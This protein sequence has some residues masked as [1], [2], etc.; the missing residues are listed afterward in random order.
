M[1]VICVHVPSAVAPD[2]WAQESQAPQH[3]VLQHTPFT[4]KPDEHW[5]FA[6]QP[7]DVVCLGAHWFVDML[8]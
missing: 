3:A 2:I 6:L 1:P 8:Q 4:Q 5:S 7:E